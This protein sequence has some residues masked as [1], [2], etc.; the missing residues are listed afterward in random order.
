MKFDDF[1]AVF[2]INILAGILLVLPLLGQILINITIGKIPRFGSTKSKLSAYSIRFLAAILNF[3]SIIVIA[4]LLKQFTVI[5]LPSAIVLAVSVLVTA[6]LGIK[7]LK[8][9]DSGKF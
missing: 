6:V 3:V 2:V 8:R 5:T 1:V 4:R 9:M 7:R